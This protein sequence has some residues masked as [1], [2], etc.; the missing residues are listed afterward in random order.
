MIVFNDN[1]SIELVYDTVFQ[2]DG[3][4]MFATEWQSESSD[5][6][7]RVEIMFWWWLSDLFN[8]LNKIITTRYAPLGDLTS[9]ITEAGLG[10]QHTKRVAKQVIVKMICCGDSD[11][12]DDDDDD[13]DHDCVAW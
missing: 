4:F 11:G 1:S 13:G 2:S 7:Y 5:H 6:D 3:Y 8:I 10:E 9:N 12:D